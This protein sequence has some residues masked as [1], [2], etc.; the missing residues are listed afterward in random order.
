MSGLAFATIPEDGHSLE[1]SPG[2]DQDLGRGHE[3]LRA[4]GGGVAGRSAERSPLLVY[5]HEGG[6]EMEEAGLVDLHGRHLGRLVQVDEEEEDHEAAGV[7]MGAGGAGWVGE[8]SVG[9]AEGSSGMFGGDTP[10]RRRPTTD[11][12]R[13]DL[14]PKP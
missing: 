7:A 13:D 5:S 6:H 2:L 8:R 4:E 3:L 9:S 1:E 14:N 10:E 12:V 11:K